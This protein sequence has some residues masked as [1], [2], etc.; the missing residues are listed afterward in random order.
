LAGLTTKLMRISIAEGFTDFTEAGSTEEVFMV[1]VSMEEGPMVEGT[2][3]TDKVNDSLGE[4]GSQALSA[5]LLRFAIGK[6]QSQVRNGSS[7]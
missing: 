7:F 5:W 4:G 1:E 6:S 3:D 2:G